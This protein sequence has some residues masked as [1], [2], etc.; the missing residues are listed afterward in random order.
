MRAVGDVDL[1][2]DG[3]NLVFATVLPDAGSLD[4]DGMRRGLRSALRA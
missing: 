2:F 3:E 4:A 1:G